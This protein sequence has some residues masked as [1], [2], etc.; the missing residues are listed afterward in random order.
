MPFKKSSIWVHIVFST[1]D[2]TPYLSWNI[3]NEI[4]EWIKREAVKQ[5]IYIDIVNGVNDHL[6]LLVKL[7]T[8][9]SVSTVVKWIKGA[10]SHYLNKKYNWDPKFTWQN[11]YAVYS[12][13]QNDIDKVRE[14][15]FNQEKRHSR[16]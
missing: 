1:K 4:C 2:R 12:V 11:G 9:Q 15:I 5:E 16:N 14:Y 7:D 8:K 13:S 6:H 3:R 10:S